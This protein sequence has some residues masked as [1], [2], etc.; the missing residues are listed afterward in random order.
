MSDGCL[1]AVEGFEDADLGEIEVVEAE[2]AEVG[3]GEGV[4]NRLAASVLQED[5][6][7]GKDVAG[8][9]GG[10]ADLGG[11]AIGGGK[12]FQGGWGHQKLSNIS[13]TTA[14]AKERATRFTAAPSS[15]IKV[16]RSVVDWYCSR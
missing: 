4:E 8:A 1:G 13:L 12:G 6:I 2:V 11:E 15:W 14:A 3:W 16:L 9:K 10:G 5:L 7:A